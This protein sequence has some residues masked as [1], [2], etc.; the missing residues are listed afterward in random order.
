MSIDFDMGYYHIK[1]IE[2]KSNVCK[3]ILPCVVVESFHASRPRNSTYGQTVRR[4][5]YETRRP[6][7]SHLPIFPSTNGAPTE[8][9]HVPI[10]WNPAWTGPIFTIYLRLCLLSRNLYRRRNRCKRLLQSVKSPPIYRVS[11]PT[12]A[13]SWASEV[14]LWPTFMTWLD[15]RCPSWFDSPFWNWFGS[16][17]LTGLYFFKKFNSTHV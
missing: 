9:L 16:P 4:S 17:F 15:S 7:H 2:N 6:K 11:Y 13:L 12:R 5:I 8:T 1:H 14:L 10:P 3:I